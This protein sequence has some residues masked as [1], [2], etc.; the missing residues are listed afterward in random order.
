LNMKKE[1][2]ETRITRYGEMKELPASEAQL[3]QQAIDALDRAYAPYSGFKVAAALQLVNGLVVTGTNQENVAFPSGLC[4]ERVAIFHASH[5]Y[6]GVNYTA[7][8]IVAKGVHFKMDH[9]AAPC[10]S[11]RQVLMEYRLMQEGSLKLIL[12][13][14]SGE[15]LV[16]EDAKELLP[17]YFHEPDLKKA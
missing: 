17:L 4:A 11:C 12:A 7:M 2:I 1:I 6:P 15:I 10:G 14:E 5:Q 8:A 9:P 16:V 13:G 3:L